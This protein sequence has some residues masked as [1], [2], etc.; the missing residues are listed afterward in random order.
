MV[1]HTDLCMTFVHHSEQKT[2]FPEVDLFP[3]LCQK[4]MSQLSCSVC[5][6]EVNLLYAGTEPNAMCASHTKEWRGFKS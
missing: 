3:S 6:R 2:I 4:V 1:Y 5:H